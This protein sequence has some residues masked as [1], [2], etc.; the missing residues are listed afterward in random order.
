MRRWRLA[1]WWLMAAG[2][3]V[4]V[5]AHQTR[6]IPEDAYRAN[7]LGVAYLEQ[8]DYGTAVTHF[9]R[10]LQAAPDLAI[11]HLNLAL[12]HFY[13]GDLEQAGRQAETARKLLPAQP[14]SQYL[15]GLIAREANRSADALAH[16]EEVRQLDADDVGTAINIGQVHLQEGRY[17]EARDAFGV[18]A[19]SEPYN[20]T[21][22]YGHATALIRSGAREQ[23]SVAMQRFQ[24]L[25]ESGY[26]TTYSRNYLEQGRYAEAI[27]STG[28]EPG[29]VDERVPDVAFRA[30]S[31]THPILQTGGVTLADHD[32]DGDLDLFVAQA[33][34]LR[35][36]RNGAGRFDEV[37]AA[38]GLEKV[39]AT[40]VLAGD[41]DNDGL[42]DLGL[43]T[44]RGP[45]LFRQSP[46][47]RF[48]RATA[49]G[50]VYPH[51]P[52]AAAWIDADHDGDIDLYVGGAA[53]ESPARLFRNNGNGTF[54]DITAAAKLE[55][56]GPVVAAVATDYDNRRDIDLLVGPADRGPVLF[57]NLRDGTFGDV[58]G[59]A[60]L[61]VRGA[62]GAIAAGDVNKD[63]F[64]D[65]FFGSAQ[66][67]ALALSDGRG[68]FARSTAVDGVRGAR[69]AL[70]LD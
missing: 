67:G 29:L 53:K 62:A 41:Y 56:S 27:V 12:A 38:S 35:L 66:A 14:H 28:A 3:A 13:N 37:T 34:G 1:H 63:S 10:A 54:A 58:A 7:N 17:A 33:G 55:L 47:G 48:T 22:A 25:R 6:P 70:F 57:R 24:R 23:G 19:T 21:A 43:L 9:Q 61:E 39:G 11:A 30:D 18:A 42:T 45:A 32:R 20:V 31:K 51:T 59:P 52:G 64:T 50:L 65:F 16:F 8:Y 68:G 4:V 36:L 2:L 26:A 46:A 5:A 60:G 49:E 69:A 40:S 15:L 44:E